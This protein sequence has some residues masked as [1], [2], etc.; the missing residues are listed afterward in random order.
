MP[1]EG[2][3]PA[4]MARLERRLE[5]ME[6]KQGQEALEA[7]RTQVR[8]LAASGAARDALVASV[9][10]LIRVAE[11]VQCDDIRLY[12]ELRGQAYTPGGPSF[13]Q[14]C[15][16]VIEAPH[17]DRLLTAIQKAAKY[18]KKVK[19]KD[20]QSASPTDIGPHRDDQLVTG[21]QAQ[22]P[23]AWGISQY[24]PMQHAQQQPVWWQAPQQGPMVAQ[25]MPAMQGSSG[26]GFSQAPGPSGL[27]N[28]RRRR[29]MACNICE[30]EGHFMR[31]CPLIK[32]LKIAAMGSKKEGK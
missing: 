21:P 28:F 20:H 8:A 29:R 30:A 3:P 15:L 14:I 26:Q 2:N 6:A 31:E 16:N 27:P 22:M 12:R 32:D 1:E 9:D 4:K 7:A 19:S 11:R 24:G 13:S 18:E 10:A 25:A 5:A 23:P 17:N